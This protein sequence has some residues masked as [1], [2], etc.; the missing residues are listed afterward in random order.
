[1]PTTV[2][3]AMKRALLALIALM[4]APACAVTAAPSAKAAVTLKKA[5][6]FVEVTWQQ[7]GTWPAK[8]SNDPAVEG[9][10]TATVRCTGTFVDTGT[11]VSSSTCF[12]PKSWLVREALEKDFADQISDYSS[13]GKDFAHQDRRL[14]DAT[15]SGGASSPGV[16]IGSNQYPVG[17]P[18]SSVTVETPDL[19]AR[20][21]ALTSAYEKARDSH[22]AVLR[23]EGVKAPYLTISDTDAQT[24]AAVKAY[25][26]GEYSGGKEVRKSK[27]GTLGEN[28]GMG[29]RL[30]DMIGSSALPHTA[31]GGPVM[32]A[33]DELVGILAESASDARSI[34]VTETSTLRVFL[35]ELGGPSGSSNSSQSEQ[36]SAPSDEASSSSHNDD[37]DEQTGAGAA[38]NSS[39]E[40]TVGDRTREAQNPSGQYPAEQEYRSGG[41]PSWFSTAW[42]AAEQFL[43]NLP[44]G[45]FRFVV[46]VAGIAVLFLIGLVFAFINWTV[47][48][49]TGKDLVS[50][51]VGKVG[52]DDAAGGMGDN[53]PTGDGADESSADKADVSSAA[54]SS[55]PGSNSVDVE[56]LVDT[57]EIPPVTVADRRGLG[58]GKVL[59]IVI[60]G[61]VGVIVIGMTMLL[62]IGLYFNQ[63]DATVKSG[64]E[65]YEYPSKTNVDLYPPTLK[66]AQRCLVIGQDVTTQ[67]TSGPG[68]PESWTGD[69]VNEYTKRFGEQAT[70]TS[71][72][73][74]VAPMPASEGMYDTDQ[75]I[76][77]VTYKIEPSNGQPDLYAT[78][79]W[80][81]AAT[82]DGDSMKGIGA[83]SNRTWASLDSPEELNINPW[84][85]DGLLM[86]YRPV[87]RAYMDDARTCMDH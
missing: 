17:I 20:G 10:L 38:P 69:M 73:V 8:A 48:K 74:G 29:T 84:P 39:G 61:V 52:N 58:T 6:T 57:V 70:F 7:S 4:L 30:V 87:V 28:V 59:A 80:R 71:V 16:L 63:V 50:R 85:K 81:T 33:D 78:G 40:P 25:F 41:G 11:I 68:A 13:V 5:T 75:Y 1:M 36:S 45:A 26:Y 22:I 76:V 14:A 86:R 49:L 12:D 9:T 27:T 32:N 19:A 44:R 55:G 51:L 77:A 67:M 24:G 3:L 72:D 47:L 65:K 54:L 60:G 21:S 31:V 79:V 83:V 82:A 37:Q 62:A 2:T 23:V 64:N 46:G 56:S 15:V 18:Y 66:R 53:S 42:N 43:D 35:R 34:H